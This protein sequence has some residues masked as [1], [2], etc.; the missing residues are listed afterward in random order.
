MAN[1][2]TRSSFLDDL[3]APIPGSPPAP[4]GKDFTDHVANYSDTSSGAWDFFR[5]VSQIFSFVKLIPHLSHGE[6]ELVGGASNV[7]DTVGAGLSLPQLISDGNTLRNSVS[8]WI[9][10]QKLPMED[11][12][13]SRKVAQAAKK[14]FLDSMNFTNTVSQAAM[15]FDQVNIFK[16]SNLHFNILNGIYNVTSIITDGAEGIGEGFK[17]N[18]YYSPLTEPRNEAE[19]KQLDEKKCLSWMTVAKDVVSVGG[20]ALAVVAII[21]GLATEGITFIALGILV[22]GT[23]WLGLKLTCYFYEKIVIGAHTEPPRP[24]VTVT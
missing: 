15:F 23:V 5:I 10:T 12:W 13:R 9:S 18:H 7:I 6:R 11:P 4:K 17:L 14:S 3:F 21:F 16:F 1:A 22:T 19:R 24:L 8:Q 20:S 2:V